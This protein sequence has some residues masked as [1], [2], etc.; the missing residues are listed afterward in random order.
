MTKTVN[1]ALVGMAIG[2]GKLSLDQKNL[3]L[4]WAGDARS[5]ISVADLMAMSGGLKWN[6]DEG[7]VTD[8]GRLEFLT[9]DAAAFAR[10]RALVARPGTKFNYSGVSPCC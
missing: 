4:Q 3:F 2:D 9:S 10:D 1:A 5:Q 6:E 7:T 8:P